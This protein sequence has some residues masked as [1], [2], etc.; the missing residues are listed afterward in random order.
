M[1]GEMIPV[2]RVVSSVEDYEGRTI[3]LVVHIGCGGLLEE[4][5]LVLSSLEAEVVA[6]ILRSFLESLPLDKE[7]G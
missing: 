2:G 4:A 3:T 1:S 6:R 7:Q 5:R